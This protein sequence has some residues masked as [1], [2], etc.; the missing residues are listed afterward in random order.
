MTLTILAGISFVF[1]LWPAV[2]YARNVRLYRRP[3]LPEKPLPAVSILIPARDEA[4]TIEAAVYAALGTKVVEFEIVVLDDH[5]RDDTAALVRKIASQDRRV[6][7]AEAPEL[8]AGWCGKQHACYVLAKQ[9]RHPVLCFID[10]DVC[11]APEGVARLAA[12]LDSSG[13]DLVSGF[14][15]QATLTFLERLLIP[16]I[17]FL[18]LGF[19]PL[20]RMRRSSRPAFGAGCGQFVLIRREA[21]EKSGGHELVKSSLHDGVTLPRAFRKFGLRTDLCDATDLAFCRMYQ[22]AGEVWRGLAK[23]A[24]E[25]LAATRLIVPITLILLAGQVL[26]LVIF[27]ICLSEFVTLVWRIP[28]FYSMIAAYQRSGMGLGLALSSLAVAAM[29]YPRVD[30]ALRFRQPMESALMQPLGIIALLAIQWHALLR[31]LL[32]RP[33]RW[34][35]RAYPA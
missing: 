23:N 9:A 6:R 19:L 8:P 7:L 11:L 27:L 33:N 34:K 30:A 17:H 12:F 22:S 21:Y 24:R 14:P 15:Q 28:D 35:G 2:I 29:Y 3:P 5:S 13:A 4:R 20:W 32:K 18:L 16:I 25:G 26:P 31:A 10:A 1:A